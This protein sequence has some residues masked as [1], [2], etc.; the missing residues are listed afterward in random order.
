MLYK[1]VQTILSRLNQKGYQDSSQAMI[2][3]PG[4]REG[5]SRAFHEK[6]KGGMPRQ[7]VGGGVE[8]GEIYTHHH[9]HQTKK[10]PP[11]TLLWTKKVDKATLKN[12]F[13][14]ILFWIKRVYY[15][16][17]NDGFYGRRVGGFKV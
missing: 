10:I 12:I 13:A 2:V 5:P 17:I 6:S 14:H 3:D 15:N 11:I 16:R 4:G 1:A 9:H 8:Y 7:G